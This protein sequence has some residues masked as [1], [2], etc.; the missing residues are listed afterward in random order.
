MREGDVYVNDLTRVGQ[1]HQTHISHH[2][3]G[4]R[5]T[6]VDDRYIEWTEG[7]SGG[8]KKMIFKRPKPDTVADREQ[9]ARFLRFEMARIEALLKP[10]EQ[11][12]DMTVDA[13]GFEPASILA[14]AVSIVGP[15][16]EPRADSYGFP[17]IKR[18][19]FTQG[20]ITIEIEAFRITE[21]L[22]AQPY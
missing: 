2:A 4:Q 10:L 18:Q 13:S 20:A 16:A 3:S 14:F 21:E 7:V 1:E 17:I 22:A 11:P 5:H 6:K 19:R 8:W 12:A 9:V 15:L